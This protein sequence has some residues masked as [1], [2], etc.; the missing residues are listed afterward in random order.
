MP[1]ELG[2]GTHFNA[3]PD[4]FNAEQR[5]FDEGSMDAMVGLLSLTQ[6]PELPS[7]IAVFPD[8]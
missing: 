4:L 8:H 6:S 5:P 2:M 1:V 7:E 3:G